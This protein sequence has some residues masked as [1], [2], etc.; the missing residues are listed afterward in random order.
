MALHA[1]LL[2][3]GRRAKS[4][5]DHGGERATSDEI[6]RALTV[7]FEEHEVLRG[8]FTFV[9]SPSSEQEWTTPVT[10]I[11]DGNFVFSAFGVCHRTYTQLEADARDEALL[12]V[13]AIEERMRPETCP[14]CDGHLSLCSECGGTGRLPAYK[15]RGLRIEQGLAKER[16]AAASAPKWAQAVVNLLTPSTKRISIFTQDSTAMRR[17]IDERGEKCPGFGE[18]LGINLH[19]A[20]SLGWYMTQPLEV[21]YRGDDDAVIVVGSDRVAIM[22]NRGGSCCT[23]S[24]TDDP[25]FMGPLDLSPAVVEA[26]ARQGLA[27]YPSFFQV[28]TKPPGYTFRIDDEGGGVWVTGRGHHYYYGPREREGYDMHGLHRNSDPTRWKGAEEARQWCAHLLDEAAPALRGGG[29]MSDEKIVGTPGR[30][31]R[32]TSRRRWPHSSSCSEPS[33][34]A[35]R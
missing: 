10:A 3:A 32:S 19:D 20:V 5:K 4:N 33:A 29:S 26:A 11:M 2:L 21:W 22:K 7:A 28:H 15:A 13:Q 34:G 17:A 1:E 30:W 12:T 23:V 9:A 24:R 14:A 8:R 31:P 25:H 18:Y 6:Q 27:P 35:A 16:S